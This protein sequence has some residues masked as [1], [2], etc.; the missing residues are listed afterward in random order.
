MPGSNSSAR[1]SIAML[2]P[3]NSIRNENSKYSV[4]MSLWLV[5]MNQRSKKLW[6]CSWWTACAVLDMVRILKECL[7]AFV[8]ASTLGRNRFLRFHLCGA[9]GL[10]ERRRVLL[11]G[12]PSV[13]LV[14]RQHLHHHR[15]GAVVLAAQHVA[16]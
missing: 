9:R 12:K 2:P 7:A 4:P 14:A 13:E 11:R 15:H 16:L 3:T 6:W 5:D 8:A 1:I 10:V